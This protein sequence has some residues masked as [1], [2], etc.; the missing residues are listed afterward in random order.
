MT[1]GAGTHAARQHGTAGADLT[2]L[3]RR[4]SLSL[5]G[6][7]VSAAASLLLVLLVTRGAGQVEAGVLF[8][9]TS[10]FLIATSICNLGT[11]TGLVYFIARCRALGQHSAPATLVRYAATPV[12]LGGAVAA[13]VLFVLADPVAGLVLGDG[14]EA[15]TGGE[16]LRVLAVFIPLAALYDMATAATQ[17]YHTMRAT[18]LIERIGRPTGQIVLVAVALTVGATW[19][20]PLAWALPYSIGLVLMGRTLHRL[21]SG[22]H[23]EGLPTDVSLRQFWSYTAPRGV[24]GVAQIVLQRMDIVLVAA[25][26]GAAQA[27]VYMAATR[28]VVL[29]Q[30]GNQAVALAVQPKLAE[31]VATRDLRTLAKVYQT[32][33]A[34]I[35]A[36]T[37]PIHLLVIVTAPLLLA[38]FGADYTDGRWVA[39]LL[40]CAMLVASSC[41]M[42]TMLLVMAG[43]T[44]WNLFNVLVALVVNL[45]LNLLLIP[46]LGIL[47]AAVAWAASILVSNLL[48]LAQVRHLVRVIPFSRAGFAVSALAL[49]C[50]GVLPFGVQAVGGSHVAAVVASICAGLVCYAAGLWW[51]RRTIHVDELLHQL[52]HRRARR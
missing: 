41:G 7:V 16:F 28:F 13:T 24:A 26:L 43:K 51:L 34:W 48:P 49:G 22:A 33:T 31:L 39:V 23:P 11:T 30:L 2:G 47:G 14:S 1:A 37:W 17:G 6:S 40:A 12:A 10:V 35:V 29:G 46:H 42:V 20:L 36:A 18:V 9:T 25:Y 27:A 50:F 44:S 19:F 21:L 38:A 15:R 3:A 52:R 8:A 4:G 32:S 5:A 45:G